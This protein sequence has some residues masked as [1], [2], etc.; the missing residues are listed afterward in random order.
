MTSMKPS[1]RARAK[2]L[3][4]WQLLLLALLF[5]CAQ[6]LLAAHEVSHA[7]KHAS[8][9]NELCLVCLAGVGL[10]AAAPSAA[11]LTPPAP[12]T[13]VADIAPDRPAPGL[14]FAPPYQPR[15]PPLRQS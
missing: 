4:R 12:A 15:A 8:D 11:H 14:A 1:P 9:G 3:Q 5:V 10:N 2:K 13:T 6:A 7:S